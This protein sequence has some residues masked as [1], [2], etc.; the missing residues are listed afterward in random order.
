MLRTLALSTLA[1]SVIS[2]V[3][4]SAEV[5][6]GTTAI[7]PSPR[8]S[9]YG[10]SGGGFRTFDDFLLAGSAQVE[11][12]SWQGFW[13]NFDQPTPTPAPAPDVTSWEVAFFADNAGAPG[14]LLASQSFAAAAVTSTFLGNGTFSGGGT[15]NAAYYD[16]R[17][18]LPTAFAAAA[19]QTYWLSILSL[20]PNFNPAFAWRASG[21]G[22]GD[23]S[24]QQQLGAGMSVVN[25][26]AV[27]RDRAFILEGTAVPEPGTLMLFGTAALSLA[28]RRRR[29]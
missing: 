28:V 16:Y 3:P 21:D 11:T 15:Y 10:T 2:A 9:D 5:L 1:L 7:S 22:L 17:V 18:T 24:F 20:S 12:V 14:A 25:A 4:A 29:R 6:F 26:V 27:A 13:V 8:T 19:G 23:S